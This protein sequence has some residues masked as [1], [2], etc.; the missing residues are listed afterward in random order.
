MKKDPEKGHPAPE[1]KEEEKAEKHKEDKGEGKEEEKIVEDEA[2]ETVPEKDY[3]PKCAIKVTVL[4]LVMLLISG[5]LFA[6]YYLHVKNFGDNVMAVRKIREFMVSR[7]KS[8]EGFNDSALLFETEMLV[9]KV[10]ASNE[11]AFQLKTTVD[12]IL[13]KV[14]QGWEYYEG[15]LYYFGPIAKNFYESQKECEE[16]N[17]DL[18]SVLSSEA[19]KY[20]EAKSKMTSVSLWI[21]LWKVNGTWKWIDGTDYSVRQV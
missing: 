7:N 17:A 16:E 18:V 12:D 14:G 1:G 15:R 20:L 6:K 21:G 5:G 3:S 9:E 4:S 10:A 2:A 8:L 11:K 13:Q 19:E